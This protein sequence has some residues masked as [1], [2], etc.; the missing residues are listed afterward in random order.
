M[1]QTATPQCNAQLV[2]C[3]Y[4]YISLA[5]CVVLL[6]LLA[7]PPLPLSCECS[8]LFAYSIGTT[9]ATSAFSLIPP[10]TYHKPAFPPRDVCCSGPAPAH[11]QRFLLWRHQR[12]WET[13][14]AFPGRQE[15]DDE[16]NLHDGR[17]KKSL[18]TD[19]VC[20]LFVFVFPRTTSRR[21]KWLILG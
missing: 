10:R 12:P 18:Y 17:L 5:L 9:H 4:L 3:C 16:T 14:T 19:R 2:A 7:S 6:P 8:S 1:Y 21:L 13:C 11:G 20:L 15:A